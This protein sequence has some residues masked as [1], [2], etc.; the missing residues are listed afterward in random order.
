[1]TP[2]IHPEV[3]DSQ[4]VP[5]GRGLGLRQSMGWRKVCGTAGSGIWVLKGDSRGRMPPANLDHQVCNGGSRDHTTRPG[6]RQGTTVCVPSRSGRGAAVR[7]QTNGS[8][9]DGVIGLWSR[10]APFLSP[11]CAKGEV[12]TGVNLNWYASLESHIPCTAMTSPCSAHRIRLSSQSVCGLSY[13][14][15]FKVRRRAPG[16]VPYSIR[17]D[18]GDTL[19]VDG[20]A[21]SEYENRT[22]SGL[23]GPQVNLTFRWITQHITSCPPA[24]AICW[25]S[26]VPTEEGTGETNWAIFWLMVLLLSVW[27][28]FLL[29]RTWVDHWRRC[30]SSGRS[31]SHQALRSPPW[32]P[33][34]WVG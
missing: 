18:H 34:R 8:I 30:C 19:V 10:V 12:P 28:C 29:G 5:P 13:S 7:P 11:W 3:P 1:M 9:W 4:F 6:S 21:Q 20:L 16:E 31:P 32:G 15:E 2:S 33:G 25:P 24:G 17:L 26:Q 23:Q 14:V 22:V 27:V